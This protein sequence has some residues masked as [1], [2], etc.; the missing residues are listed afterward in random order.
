MMDLLISYSF[1]DKGTPERWLKSWEYKKISPTCN[2]TIFIWLVKNIYG[3]DISPGA[4]MQRPWAKEVICKQF[5]YRKLIAEVS[6]WIEH[7]M[8]MGR[9]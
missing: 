3:H 5:R 8:N 4:G 9:V 2:F 1:N 6:F 7:D